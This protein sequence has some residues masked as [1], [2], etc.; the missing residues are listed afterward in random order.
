MSAS[1]TYTTLKTA[2]KNYFEN[3]DTEFDTELDAI[4]GR[5]ESR[6][7]RDL[8]LELFIDTDDTVSTAVGTRTITKPAGVVQVD[9]VWIKDSSAVFQLVERRTYSRCLQYAPHETTD[10]ADPPVYYAEQESDL[11]LSP[12]PSAIRAVRLRVVKRPTGLSGAQAT[13]WLGS[14]VGDLLFHACAIECALFLK[15]KDQTEAEGAMYASLIPSAKKEVMG[16]TRVT[17]ASIK[18]A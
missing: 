6:L 9:E 8:D 16:L 2:L 5:G 17:Y 14:N 12:T 10:T 7:L 18:G 1:Y 4:I 13:S 11:Y 3:D 15:N